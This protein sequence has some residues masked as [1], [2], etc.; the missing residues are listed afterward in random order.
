MPQFC[1][2]SPEFWRRRADEVFATA[3]E[4]RDPDSK[5]FLLQ[6]AMMYAAMAVRKEF[7]EAE[8]A[9]TRH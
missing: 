7:W 1:P 5:R 9:L 4:L 2:S 8:A 3:C 6:I